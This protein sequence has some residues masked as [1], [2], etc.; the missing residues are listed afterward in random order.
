MFMSVGSVKKAGGTERA[1]RVRTI[2]LCGIGGAI[3]AGGPPAQALQIRDNARTTPAGA[4]DGLV[5]EVDGTSKFTL[6]DA[7]GVILLEP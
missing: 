6:E 1:I 2:N 5:Q 3:Y 7:S 4:A